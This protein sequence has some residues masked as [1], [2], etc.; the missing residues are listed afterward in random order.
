M[1]EGDHT[2]HG[3]MRKRREKSNEIEV[4]QGA[5]RQMI[6][7]LDHLDATIRMFAPDID[8][9]EVKPNPLPPKHQAFKGQVGHIVF[10]ALRK[11]KEPMNV[12]QLAMIVMSQRGLNT[13]DARLVQLLGRRVQAAMSH[14]R[15]KGLVKS[16]RAEPLNLWRIVATANAS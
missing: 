12:K 9:S 8:L 7:D 10:T 14:Y 4:T 16:E 2:I 13:K 6:I 11:S 15:R 3:L 5:L 1:S